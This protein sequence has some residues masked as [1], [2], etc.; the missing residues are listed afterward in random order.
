MTALIVAAGRVAAVEPERRLEDFPAPPNLSSSEAANN[1]L[2][3]YAIDLSRAIGRAVSERDY[4][5]EARQKGW[6]GSTMVRVEIGADGLL[7][8]VTV[9]RSSGFSVL[10]DRAVAKVR[11]VTLPGIPHELRGRAFTLEV[12]FLF[13]LRRPAVALPQEG[14]LDKGVASKG[15]PEEK[16][17]VLPGPS[18]K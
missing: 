13:Q 16:G 11:T 4:P 17:L 12:P 14:E 2:K 10:D 1:A 15:A 7:K 8:D 6:G 3:L 5:R 18:L 9:T